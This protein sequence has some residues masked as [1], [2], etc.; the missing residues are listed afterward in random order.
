MWQIDGRKREERQIEYYEKRW[1]WRLR[2]D[3]RNLL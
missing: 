1:N 2:V 3:R